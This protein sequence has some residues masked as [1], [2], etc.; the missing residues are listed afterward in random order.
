MDAIA[1]QTMLIGIVVAVSCSLLGVFLVLRRMSMMVDAISH[2]VLLGIVLAYMVVNDLSSPWLMV[3]AAAIGVL[4]VVLIEL[5]VST[6][7]TSADAAAGAIF[8]FLFSL[9]IILISTR[10]RN[11]HL[12]AHAISGN[13]EFA[14]YDQ[15]TIFSV[16]LGSKTLFRSTL[17]LLLLITVILLFFKQLKLSSFDYALAQALGLMPMLLHYVLMSLVSL[18]AVTSFS[19]VGSILVVA[20]MIGPAATA[21]LLAKSLKRALFISAGIAAFNA[22]SGYLIAMYVF[23]GN[24]NIASTIASVTFLVFSLVWVLDPKKGLITKLVHRS[25]QRRELELL[26]LAVHVATHQHTEVEEAELHIDRIRQ[27]LNWQQEK[28][29]K[30]LG[31]GVGAGF[32]RLDRKLVHLTD[33]GEAF[34][35]YK[36]GVFNQ[37]A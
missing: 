31:Q 34:L 33:K 32:F 1:L 26:A 36:I 16:N 10:Y 25:N 27:E 12:D 7:R 8:P 19:A 29:K 22:A 21:L 6:K 18:T 17:V 20:M 3:G 28:F 9:A 5:L 13:L 24:V 2:T 4:T 30:R 11:T 23:G 35:N 15:I 37:E 14:A